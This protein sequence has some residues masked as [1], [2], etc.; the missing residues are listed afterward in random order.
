VI[1]AAGLAFVAAVAAVEVVRR[2]FGPGTGFMSAAGEVGAAALAYGLV[3]LV[4]SRLLRTT[5]PGEAFAFVRAA[6]PPGTLTTAYGNDDS[7]ST[8]GL[9][10]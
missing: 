8:G 5:E 4:V 6:V 3:F 2:S 10:G 9:I 1:T 7:G